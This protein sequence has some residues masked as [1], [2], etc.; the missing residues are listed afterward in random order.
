MQ[1]NWLA[2]LT[3]DKFKVFLRKSPEESNA[4]VGHIWAKMRRD[5]QHQVEE[6]QDRIAHLEQLQ[7]IF[8]EFDADC[9]SKKCQLGRTF[10]YSLM[11]L[12]TLWIDKV[13]S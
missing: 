12:I 3:W 9:T 4:L 5:A 6:V 8:P 2:F 11:L 7:S 10:Y 13:G 1:Y